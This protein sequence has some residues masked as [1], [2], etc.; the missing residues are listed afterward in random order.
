VLTTKE[1]TTSD[2][3]IADKLMETEPGVTLSE[4][5]ASLDAIPA[6]EIVTSPTVTVKTPNDSKDAI[7]VSEADVLTR[8]RKNWS[9]TQCAP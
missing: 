1:P 5:A 9:I 6:G 7:P 8:E 2:D 4:P 3:A